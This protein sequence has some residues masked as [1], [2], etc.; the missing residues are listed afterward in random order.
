MRQDVIHKTL[1]GNGVLDMALTTMNL[2]LEAADSS[3]AEEYRVHQGN[4]EV[5]RVDPG[6]EPAERSGAPCQAEAGWRQL[7]GSEIAS[8]V[9][10]KTPVA[11][12]LLRR[13]GWRRLL[14]A[15]ADQ[16]TLEMFG[17]SATPVDHQAA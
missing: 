14:L 10:R 16:V 2:R 1:A 15:C 8:H 13:I 5:R 17:V 9:C 4:V 11:Q 6:L 12:W 3:G 7:S